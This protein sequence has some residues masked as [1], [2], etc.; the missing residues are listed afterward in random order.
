MGIVLSIWFISWNCMCLWRDV[1]PQSFLNSHSELPFCNSALKQVLFPF[2]WTNTCVS[3]LVNRQ[4]ST[5]WMDNSMINVSCWYFGYFSNGQLYLMKWRNSFCVYM[6]AF[7]R[8]YPKAKSYEGNTLSSIFNS[9]TKTHV[10]KFNMIMNFKWSIQAWVGE[11]FFCTI[12][13][14]V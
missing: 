6:D 12:L 11:I 1:Y 14:T 3:T 9:C 4:H 10:A 13:T 8:W 5:M 2:V 7:I